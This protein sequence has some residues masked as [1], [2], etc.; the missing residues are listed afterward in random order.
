MGQFSATAVMLVVNE[1]KIILKV[2]SRAYRP[3]R[4]EDVSQ[5][6]SGWVNL[7]IIRN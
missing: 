1:A 2:D 4:S 6:F 7:V 5:G 3:N